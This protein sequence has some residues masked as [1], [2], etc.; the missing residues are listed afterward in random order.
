M[1]NANPVS[2]KE[3]SPEFCK[4]ANQCFVCDKVFKTNAQLHAHQRGRHCEVIVFEIMRENRQIR[5]FTN[6]WR[7]SNFDDLLES[8]KVK[9]HKIRKVKKEIEFESDCRTKFQETQ[10]EHAKC[11]N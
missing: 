11:D 3:L 5:S 8:V 9:K 10:G 2:V 7:V 6:L 1:Q 4:N